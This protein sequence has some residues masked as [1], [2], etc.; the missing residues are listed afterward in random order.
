MIPRI[1]PPFHNPKRAISKKRKGKKK[2]KTKALTVMKA[3]PLLLYPGGSSTSPLISEPPISF[4]FFSFPPRPCRVLCFRRVQI[5]LID[6][7][8]RERGGWEARWSARPYIRRP[9]GG[10]PKISLVMPAHLSNIVT[11]KYYGLRAF[12]HCR[13]FLPSP[14]LLYFFFPFFSYLGREEKTESASTLTI[15]WFFDLEALC[16]FIFHLKAHRH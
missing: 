11:R 7:P 16:F 5:S 8:A 14:F 3:W 6:A 1:K 4:P 2:K 10:R 9:G 13:F 12:I 15:I